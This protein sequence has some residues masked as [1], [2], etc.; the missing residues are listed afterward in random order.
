M[1]RIVRLGPE[2]ANQIAAGEV[3]ER[4]AS[5]VKELVENALDAGARSVGV[6]I[7][8]A[9]LRR[10][11]VV[12]D[13]EGMTPDD[14]VAAFDRHATSKIRDLRDLERLTSLGFRGEALPSI[15]AVARVR[16]TSRPPEAPT[17]WTI[18][19]AGGVIGRPAPAEGAFG[20]AV[21]VRDLFFNTP[22]RLK[23]LK[24]GKTEIGH[25]EDVV[26]REALARPD[27]AFRLAVDGR[28]RLKTAG[29]GRTEH[30][31]LQLFGPDVAA[32][33]IPVE[34]TAGDV[35][36]AGF[37]GRPELA[38]RSKPLYLFVNRR[39]VR[40]PLLV[41]GV[42]DAY[43][44][45]LLRGLYPY[46]ILHLDLDP[47]LIDVNVHPAKW[48]VRFADE[49]HVLGL[50]RRAVG[51]ALD[52]ARLIPSAGWP[53][54]E[55]RPPGRPSGDDPAASAGVGER[56]RAGV[57]FE[58][59]FRETG[60][61]RPAPRQSGRFPPPAA[62]SPGVV[63]EASAAYG[64]AGAKTGR[65]PSSGAASADPGG[66]RPAVRALLAAMR[67]GRGDRAAFPLPT[68]EEG[69]L[70]PETPE[71]AGAPETPE[72]AGA[73]GEKKPFPALR[74]LLQLYDAYIL[75]EGEDGLYIVDQHAA[76]ERV[77]YEALKRLARA[78]GGGTVRPLV[79]IELALTP[80]EARAL[81]SARS[82]LQALGF[83]LD[84]VDGRIALT[85]YPA[86]VEEEAARA[87]LIA[88]SD[89]E[90]ATV[91]TLL[92]VM[93]EALKTKACKGALRANRR[94]GDAS[95]AALLRALAE[96]EEP[97]TCPH[98]RPVLV[99]LGP[100]TL[101]RWFRRR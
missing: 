12:D 56:G 34:E 83:E 67:D 66:M 5:V 26:V 46:A 95:M 36:V 64:A 98:G 35:K 76:E 39:P 71:P 47:T 15:A 99:R 50:I 74:P 7:E 84:A 77:R 88:V 43:E 57:P 73:G 75:A 37:V 94:L 21:E 92:H 55:R 86:W 29:D 42:L 18:E 38:R 19:A 69:R 31:V 11:A 100:E 8:G 2:I 52:R 81:A 4:P 58:P 72:P 60:E 63:R 23:F 53:T 78:G 41:K 59:I 48:E 87:L 62:V 85:G 45:R 89:G 16:L 80:A 20:T 27:V 32:G 96:A 91:E 61:D 44:T 33:L 93:D 22:A 101:E 70:A 6:E 51:R 3:V 28:E 65:R 30:V 10:I 17:A 54:G 9:G 24:S 68:A 90:A 97:Y 1:G 82:A 49:G 25:M 14:L 13:G 79:P 40:A